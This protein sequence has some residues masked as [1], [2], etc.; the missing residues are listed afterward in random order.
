MPWN[1]TIYN[2]YKQ[3][4]YAPFFDALALIEARAGMTAIDLG[5]GTGEMTRILADRFEDAAFLG[6]D[7]SAEMLAESATFAT[8]RVRFE[9]RGI[10][11]QLHTGERFDLIFSNAALQWLPDHRSLFPKLVKLLRPDGQ[12]VVQMPAQHRNLANIILYQLASEEP[13]ADAL[14]RNERDLSMLNP[15]DYAELLFRAGGRD[16][17]VFEK[18]YPLIVPDAQGV[19]DFINGSALRPYLAEL[20]G[21]LRDAFSKEFL[22]R[23]DAAFAVKPVF[24]PFKRILLSARF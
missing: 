19:Y 4:R 6:I 11:A 21:E 22:Q 5:C 14:H 10:A 18:I 16:V 24:Y 17:Q 9:Q 7:T 15:E 23:L 12:L 8:A 1:P 3:E 13:F 2:Q 20:W